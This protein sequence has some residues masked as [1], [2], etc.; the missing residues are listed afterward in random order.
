MVLKIQFVYIVE[1]ILIRFEQDAGIKI[2]VKIKNR[3]YL[4]DRKKGK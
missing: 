3:K 2:N 4:Y 1:S